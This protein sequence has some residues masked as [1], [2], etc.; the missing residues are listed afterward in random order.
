MLDGF[1][2]SLSS[3]LIHGRVEELLHVARPELHNGSVGATHQ[4]AQVTTAVE[5][6]LSTQN[7]SDQHVTFRLGGFF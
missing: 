7:W 5:L 6:M 3:H 4:L 2:E 1:C